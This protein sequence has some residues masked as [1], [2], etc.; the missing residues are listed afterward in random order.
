MGQEI[1]QEQEQ[2]YSLDWWLLDQE[3][4]RQVSLRWWSAS[5]K[6]Y[7]NSPAMWDDDYELVDRCLGAARS[8][9]DL[10]TCVKY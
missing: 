4:P 5:A 8:Q 6:I 9:P 3:G 7:A 1:G 10:P 2:S